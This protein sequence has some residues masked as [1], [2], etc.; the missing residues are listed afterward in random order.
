MKVPSGRNIGNITADIN[1]TVIR[2]TPLQSSISA[3]GIT[4]SQDKPTNPTYLFNLSNVG[5][6][7]F[8]YSGS[9]LK[10][11]HT[12]ISVSYFNMDSREIDFEIVGDDPDNPEDQA[13]QNKFGAITKKVQAFGCTSRG[14]AARLGRAILFA[15]QNESETVTFTTSID[16]G[17][18]V[19][20]GSVI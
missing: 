19:R 1:K 17:L 11:R 8:N 9:S 3:G 7:G 4:L 6:G 13:R 10:T 15:E 5:E 12:I 16:S 14:Q 2:G 18:V 20:P